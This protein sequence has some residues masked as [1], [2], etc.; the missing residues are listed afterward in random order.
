MNLERLSYGACL[1]ALFLALGVALGLRAASGQAPSRVEYTLRVDSADLSGVAVE[2]RIHNAPADFRLAMATHPE[3][4][5]Q[6]WR[7]LTDLRG[8]SSRGTVGVM[9]EDS[10][11]WHVIAPAGDVTIR[12]R[13]GYPASPP[14]QQASWKAHLTPTGGLVGGPHSFL[15]VVGA[16][17]TPVRVTLTLPRGWD[18]AT[19]LAPAQAA[20]E[21]TA[22]G[23]EALLDSPML[24]GR[25]RTWQFEIDGVP[26]RVAYL[27][28]PGGI[29]FDSA[30][31]VANVERIAR[32]T[33]HLFG[34]M[35]YHQYQFQF[36]DGAFGGLEH[37]NSM[38]I[39]TPSTG[40]ARDPNVSLAQIAH[41]F[42]HTWNEVHLRPAAWIGVRHVAPAPTGELWWSEGVTLYYADLLLRRAELHT[43]ESTRLAHL[44]RLITVYTANPSHAMVSAER[45]SRAFNQPPGGNGDFIPSMFTQ[46][47]VLGA[48]LDLMIREGSSDRHSLDDVIR[49]LATRF[50]PE[51]GF[52]GGD[53]ERA[54]S[55]ACGCDARPFFDQ[56]VR[57]AGALDFNRWLAVLGLRAVVTW[58][59]ARAADGTAAADLRLS[60][61]LLA[62]EIQPRLQVWFPSTVWGRAGLH[63]GDRLVSWNGIA[64]GDAQQLRAAISQL[65]MGDTAR[66]DVMRDSG[67][68]EVAVAGVGYER[69]VVRLEERADATD[70][71]RGRRKRWLAGQ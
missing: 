26:H 66:V 34:W 5:D 70:A 18:V 58:E 42:F 41:E 14:M 43:T 62:G 20:G 64:I 3:Y 46:G 69:P 10:S 44:E 59:A 61:Y 36:E 45:T 1:R 23:L 71:Q 25:F 57:A 56:Y 21:F 27:G 40:L 9:R 4:D 47:E 17:R 24:V 54:V 37:L 6:Y 7:Y 30:L 33:A 2:M 60:G 22:P 29:P 31:F 55:D 28:Q 65:Q 38:T 48:M 15:Y 16:E 51:R 39:G 49:D 32:E 53:V 67:K 35:P 68:F 8:T 11:L 12:Y 52:T 63:T 13:V 50:T 19:G